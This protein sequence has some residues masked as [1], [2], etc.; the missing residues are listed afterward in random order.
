MLWEECRAAS[1]EMHFNCAVT[2]VRRTTEFVLETNRGAYE[3]AAL[4]V[5]TGGLSIP[6]MGA[7]DLGYRIARQFGLRIEKCFPGLVPLT[8]SA[9]ERNLYST[10]AGVST[11]VVASA[12]KRAFREK[13]LFTHQGLSGPAILQISSYLHPGET[14][15][16]DLLP[17]VDFRATVESRR[18]SGD[19]TAVKN[20]LAEC[21]PARLAERWLAANGVTAASPSLERLEEKLHG[22]QVVPAGTEGYDK[23]EVTCGGV[24]TAAL[25]SKTME[26]RNGAGLFFIGEVVDVT[27]WLGGYNFQWA[28]SSGFAAGQAV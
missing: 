9:A 25:S 7:T 15:N 1:V 27:G 12:G 20:M 26:S 13:M 6:K 17:G 5:A 18:A 23:A 3:G 11:E 14:L 16:V 8:F 10:L 21:L 22:W 4:V 2:E 19:K 28:W 24:D